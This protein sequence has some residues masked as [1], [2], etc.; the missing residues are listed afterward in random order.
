MK[1]ERAHF[2]TRCLLQISALVASGGP[3]AADDAERPSDVDRSAYAAKAINI[4]FASDPGQGRYDGAVGAP[5]DVWNFVDI[6]TT[7]VD[8]TRHPDASSSTARLRISQHDG[9]WAVQTENQIY[10]GYIYHNCQCV[11]LQVTLLDVEPG[12][13]RACVYAHGDAPDQN[14]AIEVRVGERC[15]GKKATSKADSLLFRS[16]R[17]QE[18]VQYV[19]FD[20]DVSC[21][22]EIHIIS[23]R[24]G[25]RYSMFNAIQLVPLKSEP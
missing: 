11:D 15:V 10:R 18:G 17:L 6:G 22:D 2:A 24:D 12:R 3:A 16:P 14:A 8:Y 4:G 7:A 23:H 13:Y 19:T 25:S 5:H 1:I 20:F 9:E 21:E